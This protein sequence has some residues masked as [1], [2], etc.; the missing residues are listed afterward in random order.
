MI[1]LQAKT[2]LKPDTS[3]CLHYYIYF[4]D[5]ELGLCY[6]RIPTWAPF[7]AQFYMNGHNWLETK[8]CKNSISYKKIDNAFWQIEDFEK[9]Q[10]L[11]DQLRV[12]DLHQALDIFASRYVPFIE[13]LGLKYNWTI[14]QAEYATDISFKKQEDLQVIYGN[15][16]KVAMHTV[17]PDKISSFLGKKLSLRYEGEMGN[18]FNRR[19]LGT[20]VKHHM[21]EVSIKTYDKHGIILRIESTVNNVSQ[22]RYY[23][24]VKHRDGIR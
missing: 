21:G 7:R 22:F 15:I 17:T 8:L 2:F 6:F 10:N 23:R 16:I 20:C 4:I 13:R 5:K 3:K 24:E 11:S 1:K 14:M 19:I 18:K 9:A 12:E